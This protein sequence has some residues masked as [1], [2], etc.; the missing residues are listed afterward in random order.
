[1]PTFAAAQLQVIAT[2]ILSG[3]GAS[4]IDA[5]L[6]ADEL[7]EAN[8]V[9]HDSHGVMRLMQ[10]VDYIEKGFIKPGQSAVIVKDCPAYLILDGH[11]NFGQVIAVEALQRGLV[12]ARGA[13]TATVVV[14]NCNHVGRLG[15]YAQ[16]AALSGL[17]C[18]MVVNAPGP[19]G[20]AP[21]GGIDRRLGT[22]PLAAGIPRGNE[23]I[24]LDMTTSATAEGKLRVAFQ[25]G[26]RIPEGWII[27]AEGR[28][29]TDP[30]AYYAKPPGAILPLG[31]PLGFKGFGLSVMVDFLGGLLSGSGV[32]RQDLPLGSNGVWMYFVDIEQ[33]LPRA[34]FD[35]WLAKYVR[36]I[37][38]SRTVAGTTEILMPG[39]IERMRRN[40]RVAAGISV[41]E[42]TWRQIRELAGRLSV[43]LDDV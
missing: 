43:T 24:V 15:S 19:G 40:E 12:K 26:E 27:D 39:D 28:P 14:R 17:G 5:A 16:K 33:F 25:K 34:E 3:A 29:T 18:L 2:R 21:F 32:G 11:Q 30:G 31:G 22:N 13:G 10:Y 7:V 35:D 36:N 1:M 38:T 8:L 9:G 23:P 42:E 4:E 20:V 41:P 6:V 37:Q